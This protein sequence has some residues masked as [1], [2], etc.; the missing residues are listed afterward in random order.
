M[1]VQALPRVAQLF[2]DDLLQAQ[3]LIQLANQNQATIGLHSRSLESTFKE[4]LNE[5]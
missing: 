4:A 2:L 3:S 1:L 5:S